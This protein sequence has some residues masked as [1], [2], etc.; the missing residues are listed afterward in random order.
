MAQTVDVSS[1]ARFSKK[2]SVVQSEKSFSSFLM[3]LKMKAC[4][5][6]V[7]IARP[8]AVAT[9]ILALA[10]CFTVLMEMK[11]LE[12]LIYLNTSQSKTTVSPTAWSH[13]SILST[14]R[15]FD[16]RMKPPVLTIINTLQRALP[17][18]H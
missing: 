17:P 10:L 5:L 4:G 9:I 11:G 16:D 8:Q 3:T 7:S 15:R 14:T 6:E 1:V 13:L 12:M 2:F 18:Y